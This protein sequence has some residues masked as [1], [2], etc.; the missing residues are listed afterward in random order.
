MGIKLGQK[1]IDKIRGKNLKEQIT[2]TET[3]ILNKLSNL[4]ETVNLL[5]NKIDNGIDIQNLRPAVGKVR[6]I[7]LLEVFMLK[8]LKTICEKLNITF[9]LHGGTLLGAARHKGFIPW[10]DD[11]DLGM[12]REDIEILKTYLLE[13]KTPFKLDYFYFTD[14]YFSRQARLVFREYDIPT[15]LDI[16]IYDNA[17]DNSDELWNEHC[18]LRKA[19]E[20]EIKQTNIHCDAHHHIVKD[21]EKEIL[22]NIFKKYI[23]YFSSCKSTNALIFGIEHGFGG[24]KRL[25]KNDYI[26]P[27]RKILFEN[28]YYNAPF[29]YEK[30]LE[31]QYGEYL[32]LPPDFGVQKHTYN[33]TEADYVNLIKLYDKYIRNKNIGYTAGAFDLFHIGHLNLLKRAK[34]NCNYLIVGVTT[35]ELIETT[36]GHKPA[37]PLAERMEILKACKYVD[38][39]VIQDDLDKILAWEKFHYNILFSGDDWKNDKRWQGYERELIARGEK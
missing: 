2:L 29:E 24:Y 1:V 4:E 36:K 13:N 7:Q 10:D 23:N 5:N 21:Y 26:R 6:K 25:F 32:S 8:N 28:E 14:W 9:W 20:E 17:P 33:Y 30:Y 19:L 22:D 38:E 35:D 37:I 3:Q 11:V 15:C 16:F 12:M 27:F 31:T 39:V 18:R 34:E